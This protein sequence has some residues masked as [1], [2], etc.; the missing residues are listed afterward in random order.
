[1]RKL[2]VLISI[3]ILAPF[4]GVAYEGKKE[5]SANTVALASM[6]V[7]SVDSVAVTKVTKNEEVLQYVVAQGRK[8]APSYKK[9]VCTDYVINVLSKFYDLSTKEKSDIQILT[10]KKSLKPLIQK[11]APII[12]GVHTALINSGKGV[13]VKRADVQPGDFVQFWFVWKSGAYGHCG[14]VKSIGEDTLTLYSSRP[15]SNGFSVHTYPFPHKAYF[16]RL[17]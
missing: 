5:R 17:K 10:S 2:F 3:A 11:N 13:A 16:V 1:M 7:E 9:V 12:K 15:K 6:P 8:L 4:V 14:I